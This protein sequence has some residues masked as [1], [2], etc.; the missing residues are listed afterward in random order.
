MSEEF[1]FKHH[2]ET[3][4]ADQS[5]IRDS[6]VSNLN[7]IKNQ[8][9]ENNDEPVLFADGFERIASTQ[10]IIDDLITG[11]GFQIENALQN[12]K[13]SFSWKRSTWNDQMDHYNNY[14]RL[15]SNHKPGRSKDLI[16]QYLLVKRWIYDSISDS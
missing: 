11:S 9:Y 5:Q 3:D 4:V 6:V 10:A 7:N 12:P 16:L 2:I 14:E 8:K 1:P 15:R 13:L